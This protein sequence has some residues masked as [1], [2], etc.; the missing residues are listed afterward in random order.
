[1][2]VGFAMTLLLAVWAGGLSAQEAPGFGRLE[3]GQKVLVKTVGGSRFVTRLGAVPGDSLAPSFDL[4]TVPFQAGRVDSLWVR[5]HATVTGALVGAAIVTP[6]SFGFW[7]WVCEAVS[8]GAGCT[9]W[10]AVTAASLITGA[11]GAVLGA[12]IGYLTPKWR[13]RYARDPDATISPM[14]APGRVGLSIRF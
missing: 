14:V 9:T 1:M 3:P 6:L 4:A 10:G 7:A 13:L 11:G 5:G 8:E 2:K 12:G